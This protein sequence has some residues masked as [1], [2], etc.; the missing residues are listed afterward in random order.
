MTAVEISVVT[1][2]EAFVSERTSLEHRREAVRLLQRC[3]VTRMTEAEQAFW[4]GE[5]HRDRA[6]RHLAAA[7]QLELEAA[8]HAA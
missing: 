3:Q 7:Q 4:F 8:Q 2:W 5:P 6:E 1:G